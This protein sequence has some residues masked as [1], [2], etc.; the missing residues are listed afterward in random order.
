V[1]CAAGI[2]QRTS[3]VCE[4]VLVDTYL[5]FQ[6]VPAEKPED[7][8]PVQ[9]VSLLNRRRPHPEFEFIY[10]RRKEIHD[11]FISSVASK[12]VILPEDD[13]FMS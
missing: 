10:R 8:G 12:T 11:M 1:L 13:H 5:D 7:S 2:S 4:V 3:Q 6:V 9:I